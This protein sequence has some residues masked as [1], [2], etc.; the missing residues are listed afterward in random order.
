MSGPAGDWIALALVAA[1]IALRLLAALP[2]D[3]ETAAKIQ[4]TWIGD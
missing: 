3:R 4:P 1:L 2:E